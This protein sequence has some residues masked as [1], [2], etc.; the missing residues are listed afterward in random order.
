MEFFTETEF[1]LAKH[2]PRS[3]LADR[4]DDV[5]A[6][7]AVFVYETGKGIALAPALAL[8]SFGVGGF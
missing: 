8:H 2:L 5:S 6:L 1:D 4:V 7:L 3:I